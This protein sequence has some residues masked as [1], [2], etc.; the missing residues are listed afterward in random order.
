VLRAPGGERADASSR[1]GTTKDAGA[2]GAARSKC[3]QWIHAGSEG[4]GVWA[5]GTDGAV[6]AL[7]RRICYLLFESPMIVMILVCRN[8]Q[9]VDFER[10]VG[11]NQRVVALR[12]RCGVRTRLSV[13]HSGHLPSKDVIFPTD[14]SR[15]LLFLLV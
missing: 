4:R 8:Q 14:S 2:S 13:R 9:R 1:C 15:H 6:R 11:A 5:A 10:L 3:R 7:S 12:L